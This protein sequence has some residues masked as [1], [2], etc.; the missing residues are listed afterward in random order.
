[1]APARSL[2]MRNEEGLFLGQ[3][4]RASC[5]CPSWLGHLGQLPDLP[6]PLFPLSWTIAGGFH[7]DTSVLCSAWSLGAATLDSVFFLAPC[8]SDLSETCPPGLDCLTRMVPWSQD[9]PPAGGHRTEGGTH[10]AGQVSRRFGEEIKNLSLS[11]SLDLA[12]P[13]CFQKQKKARQQTQTHRAHFLGLR[14]KMRPGS[15]G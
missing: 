3:E 10:R 11:L 14:T 1:M 8:I 9:L 2:G 4:D 6:V 5:S 12:S 13:V 15:S 7:V